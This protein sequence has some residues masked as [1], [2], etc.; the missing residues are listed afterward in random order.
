VACGLFNSLSHF[1]AATLPKFMLVFPP[2]QLRYPSGGH[3]PNT[4]NPASSQPPRARGRHRS[5]TL[6]AWTEKDAA[7]VPI[8]VQNALR[9][10]MRIEGIA[11]AEYDDF[12][13]LIAQE[14]GGKVNVRNSSSSARGLFQLLRAQYSLN[15]NGEK[16]FGN[17]VEECQGGIRYFKGRYRSAAAAR[18]F[19]Q[20]HHWY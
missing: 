7:I 1:N 15:P 10:A 9:E 11:M 18:E 13:W 16:S 17:A 6:P 12:L 2:L 3:M 14:S 20:Q 19:W 8:N 4:A 5:K